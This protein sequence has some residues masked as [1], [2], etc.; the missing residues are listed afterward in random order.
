MEYLDSLKIAIIN[1][2]ASL[3]D[4]SDYYNLSLV[5]TTDKKIYSGIPPSL[6]NETNS[7][8]INISSA[9]TYNK[10][11]I[12]MACTEDNLLSKIQIES[13]L[14]TPLI[15]YDNFNIPYKTCSI[16]TKNSYVYI[17]ISNIM[18]PTYKFRK[19]KNISNENIEA[20]GTNN[21]FSE[22]SQIIC[23]DININADN[24]EDIYY[25]I[26]DYNNT[27]LQYTL[28]KIKINNDGNDDN[29]P[30]LDEEFPILNYTFEFK[31]KKVENITMS[32]PLSCEILDVDEN[33]PE[34]QTL[35]CG[36]IKMED[37]YLLNVFVMNSNFDGIEDEKNGRRLTK[38]DFGK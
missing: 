38:M 12:F 32:R 27:Y 22:I 36:Y 1:D 25:C 20:I 3:I 5:I 33:S 31:E 7:K 15:I 24:E 6:K 10:N 8:I 4:I 37:K 19:E 14:E 18:I 11:Y 16:S 9:V 23:S 26:Y 35:I 13:G 21:Y 29:E 34:E 30:I 2:Q 17:G 28:I